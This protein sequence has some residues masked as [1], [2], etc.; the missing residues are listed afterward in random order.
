[1]LIPTWVLVLANIYFGVDTRVSIGVAT[2]AAK[3]LLGAGS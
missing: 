1:M 2:E 3:F